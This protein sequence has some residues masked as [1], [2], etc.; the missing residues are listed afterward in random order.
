[1]HTNIEVKT[2]LKNKYCVHHKSR[3]PPQ[4]SL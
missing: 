4:G 2:E 3:N 1:M